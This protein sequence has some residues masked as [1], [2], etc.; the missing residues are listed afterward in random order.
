MMTKQKNIQ[1]CCQFKTFQNGDCKPYNVILCPRSYKHHGRRYVISYHQHD[2]STYCHSG[3]IL[4]VVTFLFLGHL[5]TAYLFLILQWALPVSLCADPATACH[6]TNHYV[7]F[8][9]IHFHS[10]MQFS[11]SCSTVLRY[12][13]VT[14]FHL[15]N[16]VKIV[17]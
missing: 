6:V 5:T 9:L 13:G 10:N 14:T 16:G 17:S 2:Q 12:C 8:G 15:G 3:A 11:H 1:V 4:Y 7:L